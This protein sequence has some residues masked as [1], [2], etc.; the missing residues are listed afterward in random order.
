M[1]YVICLADST[2]ANIIHWF[3]VKCKKVTRSVLAAE[4]YGMVHGFDI[5]AI[6][7]STLT[8]LFQR[9][10]PLMLCTD[11]KSLYDCFIKLVTTQEKQLM[12][13]IMSLCQL[14]EQ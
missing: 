14:Y 3:S 2:R 12:I 10:I 5:G 8:K 13:D 4:L 11:S 6:L 9:D 1:A 7:K